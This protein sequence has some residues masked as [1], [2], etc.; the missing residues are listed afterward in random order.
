MPDPACQCTTVQL[1]IWNNGCTCASGYY[2]SES[3]GVCTA[4]V[5]SCTRCPTNWVSVPRPDLGITA[6]TCLDPSTCRYPSNP[7]PETCGGYTFLE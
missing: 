2:M 1:G 5:S 3:S 7:T 4:Y 6:C